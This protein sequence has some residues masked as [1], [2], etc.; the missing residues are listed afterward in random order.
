MSHSAITKEIKTC[1]ADYIYFLKK[2]RNRLKEEKRVLWVFIRLLSNTQNNYFST[3]VLVLVDA[4]VNV[5]PKFTYYFA[6]SYHCEERLTVL[7][8]SEVISHS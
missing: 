7:L 4:V 8:I 5:K 3:I 2:G 6:N 1:K